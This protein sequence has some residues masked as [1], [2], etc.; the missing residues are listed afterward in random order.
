MPKHSYVSAER[1]ILSREFFGMKLGLDNI[2]SFLQ[3]IGNPQYNFLTIHIAGTNG[4]GSTAATLASILRAHGYRIGLFTSPH[5]VSMRERIRVNGSIIT[6]SG[7][8]N[9]IDTY[10]SVLSRRKLSFFELMTALCLHY[11]SKRQVD[12]AVIET[13]LGGRLDATNVLAPVLTMTTDIGKD[14]VEILGNTIRKIAFEKAGI[15][16]PSTPHIIGRLPRE[17]EHIIRARCQ[18][19][20]SPLYKLSPRHFTTVPR[21]NTFSYKSNGFVLDNLKPSLFGRHQ[22]SNSALALKAVEVLE[23]R[24]I[25]IDAQ[26]IRGGL[27]SINWPGRFQ[28]VAKRGKP[29]HIF[30]VCHNVGGVEAFVQSFQDKFP[31]KKTRIITGF[32]KRKEHQKMIR[33]LSTIA[34]EFLIVPLSTRR[35]TDLDELCAG[36]SFNHVTYR[37][38]SSLRSA[39]RTLSKESVRDDVISIIGSH[40][41]VGEFIGKIGIV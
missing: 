13:G 35:S 39:Y 25:Q 12:I 27:K 5:L 23:K 21:H 22:L 32:V 6:E 11:F 28:I 17:A 30:D 33:I 2:T 1:F 37:R 4:K 38:F 14:H 10:R 15:I 26:C 20:R 18:S 8:T 24:G 19:V 7:V 41:L 40:F 31:G 3:E 9:F 29:V 34:Q 16:K 36:L